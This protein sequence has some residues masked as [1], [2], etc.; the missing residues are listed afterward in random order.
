[1]CIYHIVTCPPLSEFNGRSVTCSLGEDGVPS[2]EDT[3]S[4]INCAV[5]YELIGNDTQTCQSN[6]SWSGIDSVCRR[7]KYHALMHN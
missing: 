5:G 2:F 7:S 6:G 3:C 1:M 4:I